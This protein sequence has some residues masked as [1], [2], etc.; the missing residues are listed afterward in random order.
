MSP[1]AT[2]K[3]RRV[4]TRERLTKATTNFVFS[5]APNTFRFRSKINFTRFR[6]TKKTRSKM[7]MTLML[8]RAKM[9][10]LLAT[11]IFSPNRGDPISRIVMRTIKTERIPMIRSSRRLFLDSGEDSLF[12]N[13]SNGSLFPHRKEWGKRRRP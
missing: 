9:M 6:I 4:G 1:T 3:R 10:M 2:K 8:I 11:G 12:M 13:L 5:F 7:R